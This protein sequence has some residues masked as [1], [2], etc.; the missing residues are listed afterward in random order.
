MPG[1]TYTD[2]GKYNIIME[3][4]PNPNITISEICREH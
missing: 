1:R 3:S 2:D 4:F